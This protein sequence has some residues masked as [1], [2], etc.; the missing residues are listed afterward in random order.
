[1]HIDLVDSDRNRI[2]NL[3]IQIAILHIVLQLLI[4]IHYDNI[5]DIPL[6]DF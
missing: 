6:C 4:V 2:P 5:G 3:Q 1:M